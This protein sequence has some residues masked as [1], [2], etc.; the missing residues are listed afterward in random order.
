[1]KSFLCTFF[2]LVL[3]HVCMSQT[4]NVGAGRAMRFD[5]VD[6]MVVFSDVNHDLTLPFTVS[7]WLLMDPS[8]TYPVPIFV[9][10]D[11]DPTYRGFWFFIS[12]SLI[13]CEFG[14]GTG[15]SNP[16]FRKGKR[17]TIPN[18]TGNWVH[19]AAV[20]SAPNSVQLYVNGIDVGGESMGDSQLTMASSFPGDR[21]KVGYF[22]SN[23][24]VYRYNGLE[25]EVRLW[26]KALSQAD[27][28][29]QMCVRL[30]GLESGLVGY[31]NFDE[32]GGTVVRDQSATKNNGTAFG[33][34]ER[35]F[36]G[37]PI[38]D[39]ANNMYA[40]GWTGFT[41]SLNDFQ[42]ARSITVSNIVGDPSG[43][44]VY[45]VNSA[46]SRVEGI[47]LQQPTSSYFGVFLATL[48]S[49]SFFDASIANKVVG[50]CNAFGRESNSK[51]SWQETAK[52]VTSVVKR[53]EFVAGDAGGVALNIGPDIQTCESDPPVLI[54]TKITNAQVTFLWN[55]GATASSIQVTA[56]GTYWVKAFTPCGMEYD[57]I[58]LTQ[59]KSPDQ[60]NLG[61]DG[62]LCQGG[63]I[64]LHPY[65]SNTDFDFL[66][67]N[68]S[69]DQALVADR[70]GEYWV[71]IKNVCGVVRDTIVF[72]PPEIDR[73]SIPNVITPNG[74]NYN[75][76]FVVDNQN[77]ASCSLVIINRW[78]QRVF[79]S[80][81]YKNDWNGSDLP[82]G[83]Y[84]YY[85]TNKC[86][87]SDL[88]G[89]ITLLK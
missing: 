65:N 72:S 23:N 33:N 70:P 58:I 46:P 89:S 52:E 1:M 60:I 75:E 67:Q 4:D 45:R 27:I 74:D 5:G 26:K 7:A 30:T 16:A 82:A 50:N 13:W 15:G 59:L 81:V 22:L 39:L 80:N 85:A 57:E 44:H 47:T 71:T 28:R 87:G 63:S 55:T 24:V 76:Y 18:L 29:D 51:S 3:D 21:A 38:G 32:T 31:W 34:P 84:F 41:T 36:S 53:G 83:V 79:Q 40:T 69:T 66:W 6:D 64:T 2:F 54:D 49:S 61:P 48:N 56:P 12:N 19:V 25:D 88:K 20:M 42:D 8:V 17:A 14:D 11:N 62:K 86:S 35:V 10:N 78:G 37:A 68:G 43:I 77:D 9:T 73:Q